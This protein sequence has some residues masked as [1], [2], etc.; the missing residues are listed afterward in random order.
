MR[1]D[2]FD[3]LIRRDRDHYD[4][5][6][7]LIVS[8]CVS[9]SYS[10]VLEIPGIVH[11][12]LHDPGDNDRIHAEDIPGK[13]LEEAGLLPFRITPQMKS[14]Y[15]DGGEE[16]VRLMK[17]ARMA[18][19]VISLDLADVDSGSEAVQADWTGILNT[20]DYFVTSVEEPIYME[21]RPS[22]DRLKSLA[23]RR[24]ITEAVDLR[25]GV[26]ALAEQ[27]LRWGAGVVLIKCDIDE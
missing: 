16:L 18:G 15:M 19:T 1:D 3:Q 14:K 12:F 2:A 26:P 22:F 25:N 20:V 6:S 24:D 11:M 23:G 9:I 8:E 10:V 13:S 4:L 7:G 17:K 27:C 5:G 21:D